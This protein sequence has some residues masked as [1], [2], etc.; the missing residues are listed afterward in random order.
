[1]PGN[2]VLVPDLGYKG[3]VGLVERSLRQSGSGIKTKDKLR[4]SSSPCQVDNNNGMYCSGDH[5]FSQKLF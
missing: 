2:I 5:Q 1:L 3:M 4:Q